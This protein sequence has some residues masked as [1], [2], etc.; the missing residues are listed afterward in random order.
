M[1]GAKKRRQEE[2]LGQQVEQARVQWVGK[3]VVGGLGDGIEQ[4]GRIESI[5]DD[6]DVVLVCSAPYERVLV[7]SLCF[8][9]LFRL[10]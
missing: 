3:F 5:S 4:Y 2:S 7:F 1:R 10:A 9:S 6:G 8:L